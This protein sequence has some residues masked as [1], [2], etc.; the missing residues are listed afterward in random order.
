MAE[1]QREG[2]TRWIGLSNWNV[3]Q[4]RRAQRSAP[5]TSLQPPYSLVNRKIEPE[6]LP[7]CQQHGI[8]V[9]VYSP[10]GSGLLTGK[11]SK[12]RVAQLPADDWRHTDRRF[13]DPHLSY[14]L[15]IV[16]TLRATG[17]RH[18]HSPG[19]VA[20]AWTLAQPA[21]TAAIVGARN[22]EQVEQN[23]RAA[24]LHLSEAELREIA[25]VL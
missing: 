14:A 12:E 25:A 18:G 8:G 15:T 11:M 10:M 20:I 13:Q 2:K 4:M 24:D 23:V 1:L 16:E 22:A 17:D 19:E 5:I 6:I 9:I 3:E 21:V 7:Y